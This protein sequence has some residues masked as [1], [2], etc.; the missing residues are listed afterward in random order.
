[1]LAK[2]IIPC[3]DVKDGRTVK[4]INFEGLRDVGDA[5]ALGSKYAQEGA[6]ELVY[7]DISATQEGRNTFTHLVSRIAA[8]KGKHVIRQG[9]REAER[10][11]IMS[12]S[13]IPDYVFQDYKSV[14]PAFLRELGVTM[15]MTDLDYTLAPKARRKP[16]EAVRLWLAAALRWLALR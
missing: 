10:G 1:M 3:L 6:D 8:E 15:L 4:G 2:R 12:L 14:T 16:D 13:L 5:V 11:Q 7:L 9:I